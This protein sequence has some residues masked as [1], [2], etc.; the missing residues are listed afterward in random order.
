[1]RMR[2]YKLPHEMKIVQNSNV[3][4]DMPFFSSKCFHT[5]FNQY[6]TKHILVMEELRYGFSSV[7]IFFIPIWYSI[8]SRER[9]YKKMIEQ[10]EINHIEW[11]RQHNRLQDC[12]PDLSPDTFLRRVG[13]I[14][15][16]FYFSQFFSVFVV[17]F[18][19]SGTVILMMLV[20]K[21]FIFKQ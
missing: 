7:K 17:V 21:D 12:E 9:K 16:A 14:V 19:S 5:H 3:C 11:Q 20:F 8:L 13:V 6:T 15:V 18:L 1:M 2:S 4:F 10:N